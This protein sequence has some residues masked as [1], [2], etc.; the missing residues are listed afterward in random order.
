[1][2]STHIA[3][4]PCQVK[5]THLFVQKPLGPNCDSDWDCYGYTV[6]DFDVY[7]RKGY[8]ADWLQRKMTDDDIHRIEQLLLE[9][10]NEL[11]RT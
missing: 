8:P 6:V 1:M 10:A 9:N 11:S 7:D 3:G 4:I 2:L 5:V